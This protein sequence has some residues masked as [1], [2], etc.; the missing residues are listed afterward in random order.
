MNVTPIVGLAA[1]MMVVM[2]GQAAEERQEGAAPNNYLTTSVYQTG[3][4]PEQAASC[5]EKN[6]KEAG[7]PASQMQPLY[8]MSRVGVIMRERPTSDTLAVA[9][10]V[11][12][13]SGST[14][15]IGTTPLVPDRDKLVSELLKGC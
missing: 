13:D 1:L 14:V 7:M 3:S 4:S 11:P 5:V 12:T 15:A 2:P 8:G 9:V 6:A 10:T